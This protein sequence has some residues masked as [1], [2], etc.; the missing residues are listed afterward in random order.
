MFACI[1]V[2]ILQCYY[3]RKKGHILIDFFKDVSFVKLDFR[4]NGILY[5]CVFFT[6][7]QMK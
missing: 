6:Y 3:L 5:K 7:V 1:D 4:S 2:F